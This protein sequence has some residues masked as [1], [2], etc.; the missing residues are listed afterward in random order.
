[1]SYR[2]RPRQE[3]GTR[4]IRR[5]RF[6]LSRWLPSALQKSQH[7]YFVTMNGHRLKR[8]VQ[9]DSY[10]AAEIEKSLRE[11]G[12]TRCLP[13]LVIRYEREV[14]VEF[15]AGAPIQRVDDAVIARFAAFFAEIHGRRPREVVTDGAPF[16]A[17]LL[18][19]L[20]FL[21]KV[22][23][24]EDAACRDVVAGVDRITPETAWVG[25]EY[26]DPVLKNF[27][28]RKGDGRICAV[29]VESL[30]R[31]TQ[32]GIGVAKALVRWM[33][34]HRGAFFAELKKLDVPNFWGYLPYVELVF[35]A[36]WTTR[37]YFERK[38]KFVNPERI[39]SF[40]QL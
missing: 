4:L 33:E 6:A 12:E 7:L 31:D 27:V 3:S 30:S 16:H 26:K 17:E 11:F 21:G 8:V 32:I 29:D 23:V 20:R 36:Q 14:W 24:L 13:P 34:P 1:M 25:F 19:N 10:L 38:W 37:A 2:R 39:E 35:L 9:S 18:Q 5:V 40:R 15:V 28:L 22:G